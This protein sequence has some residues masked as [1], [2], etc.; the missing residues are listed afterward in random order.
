[1]GKGCHTTVGLVLGGEDARVKLTTLATTQHRLDQALFYCPCMQMRSAAPPPT[2]THIDTMYMLDATHVFNTRNTPTT[3]LPL[4]HTQKQW[5]SDAACICPY[6]A[7]TR[8]TFCATATSAA[9]SGACVASSST[10]T[11]KKLSCNTGSP[12]IVQYN[13]IR[14]RYCKTTTPPPSCCGK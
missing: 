12:A 2:H 13:T 11:S 14:Y 1:V 4:V 3:H 9:G 10:N 8:P 5:E 6:V 7:N